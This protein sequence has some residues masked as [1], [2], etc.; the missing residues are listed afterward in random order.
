MEVAEREARRA[1]AEELMPDLATRGVEGVATTFTDNAGMT[2]VK[3]VPLARLPEL[4]A[5]GVGC[6]PCFDYFRFDDYLTSPPTGVGPIGDLRLLPDLDRVVPLAGQPGWAWS[7]GERLDQAGRPHPCCSRSLLG[8]LV[9]A[10]AEDGYAIRVGIEIE[11]VLSAGAGDEFVPAV[12][13]PGYGLDRLTAAA[14][15]ARELLA[16]LS[17]QDVVVEQFHPEYASGQFEIS[18]A[19]TSPV[20]AADTTVLVRSTIR[21]VGARR[22]WRTSFSPKVLADGVGNGGHVHLSIWREGANLMA[23]GSGPYGLTREG[24]AFAAGILQ[25]LAPLL[26]VGAPSAVSYLRLVPSHWAGA[27][28]CW[29]LENREAALRMITGSA[30][31]IERAA[32]IEIKCVDLT[33]NPYLL[34]AALMVAGR[35][36]IVEQNSL[37]EPIE[38]DPAVCDP[39]E[40]SRRG[41]QRLPTTLAETTESFAADPA[42][43]D[44]FG[45]ELVEAILAVRR[46]EVALFSGATAETI[47]AAQ[48]WRH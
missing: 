4:A 13:G 29:G 24:E 22:G 16:A 3:A 43:T 39:A 8:R 32:N 37:P 2:R 26:A 47:I 12:F 6:S 5:W 20:S 9:R 48:R 19:A 17:G 45:P 30:G 10:A 23:G 40:L 14:D 35:A 42:L 46:S 21:S 27:Y 36:G 11:W 41:I 33:A 1:R 25:R 38:L 44:A 7:P 34:L 31:S 18:V 15:Y 28:A